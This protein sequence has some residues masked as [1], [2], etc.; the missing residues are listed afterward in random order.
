LAIL[1]D[2]PGFMKKLFGGIGLGFQNFGKNILKHLVQGAVA[3]L[4]G[5]VRGAGIV[6]PDKFD[7]EG[8]LSIFLQLT[9]LTIEH[10]IERARVIWGDKVVD[11]ILKG[12]AGAE[13]AIE[14]FQVFKKEGV[15][16][17]VRLLKDKIIALKDQA[18]EKIKGAIQ[19]AIVEAAIKFLLG[20]LTP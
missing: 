19:V 8:I 18:L 13:K 2:V 6:L 7:A 1:A 3:W 5:A 15:M 11:A 4:T 10:V 17:L 14:L 9:G 20:L 12:V 16:G